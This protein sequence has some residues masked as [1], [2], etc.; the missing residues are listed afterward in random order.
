MKFDK[1]NL[2]NLLFGFLFVAWLFA[3]FEYIWVSLSKSR[4][5][6]VSSPGSFL[7]M[8]DQISCLSPENYLLPQSTLRELYIE[9]EIVFE[10]RYTI[11]D[12][13]RKSKEPEEKIISSLFFTKHAVMSFI[14][15]LLYNINIQ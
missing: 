11:V 4:I 1:V 9:L 5:L 3:N 7:R 12:L 8:I 6:S 14:A 15:C 2:R 13:I 10:S